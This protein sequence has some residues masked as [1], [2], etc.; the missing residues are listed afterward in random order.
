MHNEF[1]TYKVPVQH[2]L[3][4]I[5][6]GSAQT[7]ARTDNEVASLWLAKYAD[8]KNTLAA[9]RKE[10]ERFLMWL[11]TRGLQLREVAIEDVLSY[12]E[13]LKDPQ[14]REL[15]CLE[16]ERR[17]LKTGERNPAFKPAR[18]VGR[19]MRDGQVNPNWKPFVAGLGEVAQRQALTVLF[20]LGEFLAAIGYLSVNPFRAARK[21]APPQTASVVRY[22]ERDSL[23]ALVSYLE[24]LPEV[25]EK[26]FAT[27]ERALFV[28]KFL[29]LTGLRRDEIVNLRW[30][31]IRQSRGQW[32]LAVTGKGRK[33]GEIP[34]NTNALEVLDRYRLAMH[35]GKFD[36][37]DV[38]PVLRDL[39]GVKGVSGKRLHDIVKLAVAGC[40]DKRLARVSAHWFRHS[41]AS[42]MLESGLPLA[43]VRDNLRHANIST[44]SGYI[45]TSKDKRHVETEGHRI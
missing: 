16:I 25:T 39:A 17:F 13:F 35:R 22:I 24:S 1:S 38:G 32:W 4:A 14:P 34:L 29:F 44:T 31:D 6:A 27:K 5:A 3:S 42:H 40:Q 21:K 43:T 23:S 18:K 15:W 26:E 10:V 8:S 28:V 41:A 36:G 33:A 45:H 9:Y 37:E 7:R 2:G 12:R 11:G 19:Y 30:E 20:G